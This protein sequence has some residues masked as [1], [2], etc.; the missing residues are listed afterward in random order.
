MVQGRST[1]SGNIP[2]MKFRIS[3]YQRS[4]IVKRELSEQVTTG[5]GV[6]VG[7]SVSL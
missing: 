5:Q 7:E 4:K 1:R 2:V 6:G 3:E